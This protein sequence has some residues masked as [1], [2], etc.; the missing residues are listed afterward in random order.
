MKHLRMPWLPRI[1]AILCL[2]FLAIAGN[3]Q[4][5]PKYVTTTANSGGYY[6]YLPTSYW[7]GANQ[8]YPLLIFLQGI[9]EMGDGSPSQLSRMAWVGLP[10]VINGGRF[11]SSFTVNGQTFSYIVL[12]PQFK[13]WPSPSDVNDIINYAIQ[14]YR[15]DQ[16]R[17]YVTGLSMGGGV[18]WQYAGTYANRVAAILPICGAANFHPFLTF[19]LLNMEIRPWRGMESHHVYCN[20]LSLF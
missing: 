16:S 20:F 10:G 6:E 18:T 2:S 17:I 7:N 11:P 12:A 19:F 8:S 5:T 15:V 14:N 13:N 9:G 4:M 1:V 3:A